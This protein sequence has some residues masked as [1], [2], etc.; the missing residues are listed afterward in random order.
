MLLLLNYTLSE[1]LL[2]SVVF[3]FICCVLL[4][5]FRVYEDEYLTDLYQQ[6]VRILVALL[7]SGFARYILYPL[8]HDAIGLRHLAINVLLGSVTIGSVNC[9]LGV[10]FRKKVKPKRCVVIGKAE[11]EPVLEEIAKKSNGEFV[12]VERI[13]PDPAKLRQKASSVDAVVVADYGLFQSVRNQLDGKYQILLLPEL[14]ERVL[15]R[16]PLEVAESFRSYYEILFTQAKESPAKRVLD[17]VCGLAGLIIFSPV[18][19][20]VALCILVEDGRPVVFKQQRVG[21][22]GKTFT[23]Y[24]FRTMRNEKPGE[25]RFVDKEAHRILKIGR[26]IRPIRLD[27]TLQ[28][29]NILKG[30]MSI[31][32]PRPEQI[33]FVKE[34]EQKLPFYSYRHKLKPGLTGWA[35][36]MYKYASN[37]EETRTKL[38]Y[39]LYYVKNRT[40]FMDIAILLQTIEAVIWRRGAK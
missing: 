3:S 11:I 38:S 40:I 10:L 6:F 16:I 14:A 29:V 8:F 35:Q 2:A 39:D 22:D 26:L 25:A 36:I 24:K 4:F 33:D 12:F 23:I 18:M 32:G 5:A 31:V 27:E 9:S 19:L 17:I 15:K 37:L 30:D 1:A 7:L 28:F 20:V 13:N 21:R 34:F